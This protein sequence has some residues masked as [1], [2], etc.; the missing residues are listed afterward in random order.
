MG[1][2]SKSSH[3][4]LGSACKEPSSLLSTRPVFGRTSKS[5]HQ[6]FAQTLKKLTSGL[7]RGQ[8]LSEL[9]KAHTSGQKA[10]IKPSKSSHRDLEPARLA[11]GEP[12]RAI[13]LQKAHTSLQKAHFSA[14]KS[15]H[16]NVYAS[17]Q[18][19]KKLTPF[20]NF[21]FKSY[22]YRDQSI[23]AFVVTLNNNIG[24]CSLDVGC[25]CC[26]AADQPQ[27][28]HNTTHNLIMH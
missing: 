6:Y 28:A 9:Q 11:S 16:R 14:S 22:G 18:A 19:L 1:V 5:S 10:H 24:W 21:V 15:S 4:D 20:R 3:Q 27:T 26:F 7:G 2:P 17:H 23:K 12:G 13:E 25:C 8:T